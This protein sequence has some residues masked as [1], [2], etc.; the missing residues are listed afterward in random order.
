MLGFLSS[1]SFSQLAAGKSKFLGSSMRSVRSNFATYWNQVTPDD[2]GKWGS[3][4]G[5][6]GSYNW[7]P[8]DNIYNYAV[9]NGFRYKHHNLIWG[10]QQ[11]GWI[12]TL[13]SA[14][15][16]AAVEHWID[17]VAQ[18]YPSTSFVDVVNEPFHAPPPY[19]NALGGTGS[20]GWDWVITAFNLARQKFFRGVK[21]LI[22]EYNVLQDNTVT[23]NYIRLIDTL[24][25]RGLVDGIGIQGHYF[26][27]KSA[28]GT[29]PVYSYPT[30]TLK[31][32]LHRLAATGLPIYI[33]EF[34][35]NEANDSTQLANYRI[36]FPLFWEEPGVKGIT[37]WGYVQND[38]W[39]PNAYLIRSNGTERPVVPWLRRYIA[40]PLPPVFVSP[41]S[42]IGEP[43]NPLL[44]WH[45]SATALSYRVQISDNAGF[46][47]TV[48]DTTLID[49][50]VRVNA[51]AANTM[52]YWR[53]NAENDSGASSYS[54]TAQFTTG[55]QIF[56]GVSERETT[57]TRFL[58]SQ[59]YPNPFNPTT[60]I[61]YQ[62]PEV[63][64]VRLGV[65][66][67]LGREIAVPVNEKKA[68]GSYEV[69]FDGSG[70]SSG[71]YV[72]RLTSGQHVESRRMM[73]VK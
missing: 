27:F 49:T 31:S 3:V 59:N 47:S 37:L 53:V 22:N 52:F 12:T 7:T 17:T 67:I 44:V 73:L 19:L 9:T 56:T 39:Q 21:L 43:R 23:S 24:R 35:I 42:T 15:Q 18:R 54:A 1:P 71:V 48:V 34:D 61:R 51:L 64:Q 36:Y 50:L 62:V 32:N 55:D 40:I 38:I 6:Q 2:A 33:S 46:S 4:E 5:I 16:R 14:G 10:Q 26:E 13:D 25:V 28:A 11:P 65:Y 60:V 57:P 29:T 68:P 20:T 8:L 41:D 30:S 45:R 69:K 63:S 66:D 72:Y 70:L 58:L